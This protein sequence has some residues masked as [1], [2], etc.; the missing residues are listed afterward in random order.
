MSIKFTK[1]VRCFVL[2]IAVLSII[3]TPA[4]ASEQ[5]LYDNSYFNVQRN[6]I[7]LIVNKI[8]EKDDMLYI[9]AYILNDTPNKISSI[10]DFDLI[11]YD[12]NGNSFLRKVFPSLSLSGSLE[13]LQ[14]KRLVLPIE[15]NFY[16]LN[17]IDLK[18]ITYNFKYN[19]KI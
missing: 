14:G 12:T 17:N 10:T 7:N 16:N 2:S 19:F 6:N 4:L 5:V 1:T 8:I 3:Y 13:P 15:Q 9:D 18:N 11:L